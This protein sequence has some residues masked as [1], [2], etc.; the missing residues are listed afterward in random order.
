MSA[1]LL[2][3]FIF[4]CGSDTSSVRRAEENTRT[5]KSLSRL[6]KTEL[7]VEPQ[8]FEDYINGEKRE[9]VLLRGR[10]SG[11][12]YPSLDSLSRVLY[13]W[14]EANGW[15]PDWRYSADGPTG[16]AFAFTKSGALHAISIEIDPA[17]LEG[18]P[19]DMPL[20]LSIIPPEKI[21][22]NIQIHLTQTADSAVSRM[23]P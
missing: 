23:A 4:S 7:S 22:Y 12:Q 1:V 2:L 17:S 11:V 18:A 3:L 19:A 21:N 8:A 9:A 10:T 6:L 20:D 13:S 16:T 15:Q 14:Y 5:G